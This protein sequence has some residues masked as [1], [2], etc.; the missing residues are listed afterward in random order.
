MADAPRLTT[1]TKTID[2][3]ASPLL[4]ADSQRVAQLPQEIVGKGAVR[5]RGVE[6]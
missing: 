3:P 2:V 6:R 1:A 5:F 4:L